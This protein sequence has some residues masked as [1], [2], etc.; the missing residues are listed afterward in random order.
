MLLFFFSLEIL[1]YAPLSLKE[2]TGW[3]SSLLIKISLFS[4]F[5]KL[6][7]KSRGVFVATSYT[8]DVLILL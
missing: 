4:F 8:L 1:W 5:D 7:A 6:V 2:K 3:R